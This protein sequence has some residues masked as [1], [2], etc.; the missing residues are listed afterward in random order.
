MLC[1]DLGKNNIVESINCANENEFG[2]L[3]YKFFGDIQ[4]VNRGKKEIVYNKQIKSSP[5]QAPHVYSYI[6]DYSF[7]QVLDKIVQIDI[8]A[9]QKV[10]VDSIYVMPEYFETF[11]EIFKFS[12]NVGDWKIE[13]SRRINEAFY[14]S[15]FKSCD[16]NKPF[17]CTHMMHHVEK[18][19]IFDPFYFQLNKVQRIYGSKGTGKTYLLLKQYKLYDSVYLAPTNELIKNKSK[20]FNVQGFTA[21]DYFNLMNN[22]EKNTEIYTNIILDKAYMISCSYMERILKSWKLRKANLFI[23]YDDKQLPLPPPPH[24]KEEV[25]KIMRKPCP[26]QRFCFSMSCQNR[27][28]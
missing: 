12:N 17:T 2:H 28:N 13:N 26:L 15:Q 16:E 22:G 6:I 8:C 1:L 24:V 5:S 3:V 4:M 19:P 18:I 23:L 20:E 11:K 10:K 21:H 14:K 27:I 7:T 9:L 25:E